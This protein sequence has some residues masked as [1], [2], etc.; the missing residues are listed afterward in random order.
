MPPT[1]PLPIAEPFGTTSD[2][3]PVE[4]WRLASASGVSAQ[5]L[6]Y[7]GILHDLRVPDLAGRAETVVLALPDVASY[8]ERSPFYGALIGRYANRIAGGRFTL[9][10]QEH[11]LPVNDRGN[12]LHGGPEGFHRRLWRAEPLPGALRLTLDSPDGDMG[13]PG[14]VTVRATYALDADGTLTLDIEARADRPT[15]I[16][17]TQHA[18]FDLAGAGSVLGHTLRVEADHYLPVTPEGIP[19]GPEREVAGTPFD[20]TTARPIG[21]RIEESDPQ[22]TDAGGYDHCFVL[23]VPDGE[24]GPPRTAAVL[25]DP[26]SGRTLE[27]RTTEPGLQL[28]TGNKLDGTLTGPDGRRHERFGG[29]CLETQHLPDSPNR[30]EYP[31]T[32]LRPGEVLRTRTEWHFPHLRLTGEGA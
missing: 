18:Y 8:E 32:V 3:R 21:A 27:L 13:F 24:P 26:D 31:S 2:G 19:L 9:D 10:G 4:L 22:L 16:A 25:H 29:V 11:R 28:Y 23:R 12:T 30:P 6:T 7:G 20:F 5:I 17:P 14:A 1:A 15:V